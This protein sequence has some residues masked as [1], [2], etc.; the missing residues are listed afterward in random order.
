MSGECCWLQLPLWFIYGQPTAAW[1]AEVWPQSLLPG[2]LRA[3]W[4]MS[5]L[6]CTAW[7]A[8]RRQRRRDLTCVLWVSI[9]RLLELKNHFRKWSIQL[10]EVVVEWALWEG[11]EVHDIPPL[12]LLL[13]FYLSSSLCF[14]LCRAYIFKLARSLQRTRHRTYLWSHEVYMDIY[15]YRGIELVLSICLCVRLFQRWWN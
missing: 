5:C 6:I 15:C 8:P 10:K 3:T 14:Y 4:P 12:I 1:L 11:K 13:S 9:L 7:G 2:W